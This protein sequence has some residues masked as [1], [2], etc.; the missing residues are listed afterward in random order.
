M[1]APATK[2]SPQAR[3]A[4]AFLFNIGGILNMTRKMTLDITP[5]RTRT[6]V[7]ALI[8]VAAAAIK[9]A[10]VVTAAPATIN[11]IILLVGADESQ[12]VV[13]WYASAQTS[14][15]VQLAPTK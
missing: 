10:S 11:S 7:W 3:S 1:I 9:L 12:R 8:A 13:N 5:R 2:A 4:A 6:T 14:H 15:V